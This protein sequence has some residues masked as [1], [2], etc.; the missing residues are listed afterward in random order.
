MDTVGD[1]MGA[2]MMQ[3]RRFWGKKL[4]KKTKTLRWEPDAPEDVY[5][6]PTELSLSQVALGPGAK[7]NKEKT[8]LSCTVDA[9]DGQGKTADTEGTFTAVLC[10][11]TPG[12]TDQF[13]MNLVFNDAVTFTISGPGPLYLTGVEIDTEAMM[14]G[15]GYDEDEDDEDDESEEDEDEGEE[16]EAAGSKRK[17]AAE[18]QPTGKRTKTTQPAAQPDDEDD[19]DS[20]DEDYEAAGDEDEEDEDEED[21][22]EEEE[23]EDEDEEESDE[24]EAEAGGAGEA[25]AAASKDESEEEEDESE[26]EDEEEEEEGE[27]DEDEEEEEAPAKKAP[28]KKAP[29]KKAPAAAKKGDAA[30]EHETV[31]VERILKM[32][33]TPKKEKKFV[34]FCKNTF[35]LTDE[36]EIGSLWTGY[37]KAK[38]I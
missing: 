3:E 35:K 14:P 26:D 8:V 33:N 2:D 16:K 11:L 13:A 1:A 7:N 20:E 37:K 21:E 17:A 18:T 19:D 36:K 15:M 34:N 28:A 4:D 31:T 6:V 24:A 30:G 32:A 5:D 10:T 22:D 38:G 27:S 12:V 29:A 9:P 25:A 23:E